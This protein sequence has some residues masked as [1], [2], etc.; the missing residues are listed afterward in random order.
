MA[1]TAGKSKEIEGKSND[2]LLDQSLM[3]SMQDR[4]CD[5]NNVYMVC[6][7]AQNGVVTKAYGTKEELEYVYSKAGRERHVSLLDKMTGHSIESVVEEPL[8]TDSIKMSG[9]AI[10]VSGETIAVWIVIGIMDNS[11]ED[12][13]DYIMRTSPERYY[14]SLEFL[15]S[16]S[17]QIFA[18]K[19]EEVLA[20]EA[21]NKKQGI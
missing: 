11:T 1:F 2:W 17:K 7:N 21:F 14:K 10:H 4:F 15:E 12:I 20:Q 6:L 19:M 13:P 5:A 8:D 16:L 18:V 9:V 3:Q